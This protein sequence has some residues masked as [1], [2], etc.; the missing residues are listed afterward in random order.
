MSC[1]DKMG[2]KIINEAQGDSGSGTTAEV[3]GINGQGNSTL[4]DISTGDTIGYRA[5]LQGKAYSGNGTGGKAYGTIVVQL[6]WQ[7]STEDLYLTYEGAPK[8]DMGWCPCTANASVED[9]AHY[10]AIPTTHSGE[11]EG[12]YVEFL[13]QNK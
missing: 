10:K 11:H 12:C 3:V 5:S 2:V 13:I 7:G 9:S 8:N 1:C 6:P 4:R